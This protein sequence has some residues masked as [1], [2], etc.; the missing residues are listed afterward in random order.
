M[1][2][3]FIAFG[4]AAEQPAYLHGEISLSKVQGNDDALS[5]SKPDV[6]AIMD[7]THHGT[8]AQTHQRQSLEWH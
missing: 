1:A 5:A 3:H 2:D 7:N 8:Q 4:S 6:C